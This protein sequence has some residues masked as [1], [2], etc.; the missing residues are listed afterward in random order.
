[1]LE[2]AFQME[3]A[4]N[5]LCQNNNSLRHLTISTLEWSTL[6]TAAKYLQYFKVLSEILSGEKYITLPT[7]VVGF[8]LLLDK[9]EKAKIEILKKKEITPVEKTIAEALQ[10]SIEKLMKHYSKSN[11]NYC[12]IL[13]LDPKFKVETFQKT[14]LGREM[15]SQSLK[16]FDNILKKEYFNSQ[17]NYYKFITII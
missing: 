2:K 9:L 10:V 6:R 7:V 1:M 15:E 16:H 5:M 4:L 11:W 13:V 17:V 12:A 8:N 3:D 14:E